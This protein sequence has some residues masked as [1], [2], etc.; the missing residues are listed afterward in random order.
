MTGKQKHAINDMPLAPCRRHT[1]SLISIVTIIGIDMNQDKQPT[2]EHA[3]MMIAAQY[4][5]DYTTASIL[6]T[7]SQQSPQ[8]Q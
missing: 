5:I 3:I 7:A 1:V 6:Y 4:G 2:K 8:H